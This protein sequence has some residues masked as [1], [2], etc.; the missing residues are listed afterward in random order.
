MATQSEYTAVANAIL[1]LIRQNIATKV[2][3]WEQGLI[4][5]D[6]ELALAGE[7]AKTAVDTLDAY[8]SNEAK[9]MD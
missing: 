4:P 1:V 9:G 5:D 2:P 3:G 8:R 6:L 7:C